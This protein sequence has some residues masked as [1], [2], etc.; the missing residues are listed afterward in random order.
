VFNGGAEIRTA[1]RRVRLIPKI[2]P[3]K[4]TEFPNASYFKKMLGK[5]I[6]FLLFYCSL[7][8]S[9]FQSESSD[10]H[11][12]DNRFL[13]TW[14][15]DSLALNLAPLGK[16]ITFYAQGSFEW[17]KPGYTATWDTKWHTEDSN[18]VL[19]YTAGIQHNGTWPK[20]DIYRYSFSQDIDTLS[21][22]ENGT[23]VMHYFRILDPGE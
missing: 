20:G 3:K 18:L 4:R 8:T 14:Q 12:H 9:C 13:G 2:K 17:T 1:A 11:E 15:A 7:F 5:K 23:F 21:L 10:H 6:A 16:K 19:N 22:S